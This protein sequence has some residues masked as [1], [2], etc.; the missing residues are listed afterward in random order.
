MAVAA[1]LGAIS[2]DAAHAQTCAPVPSGIVAWWPA[3]GTAND[4][5]GTN[6]G[7]L[8]GGAGFTT[9]IVGQAFS[10]DGVDGD[11]SF[12]N[13]PVSDLIA[14]QFTIEYWANPGSTPD[15]P[16]W[17]F[18]GSGHLN[19]DNP[20]TSYDSGLTFGDG[21]GNV[22]VMPALPN[23]M[24]NTWTHY[25]IVDDGTRYRVYV[26]GAESYNALIAVNPA[27]AGNR[28]FVIG[29]SGFD[30]G[31][32]EYFNG[33]LDEFTIYNRA[34]SASEIAG[35]YA[36]GPTGK[37]NVCGNGIVQ[38]GEQCDDGNMINGDGCDNNCTF[39][40]CG[41]MIVTAGEECD[42]GNLVSGDCCSST[43]QA[44]PSGQTCFDDGN[45]CTIDQCDGAG[46]CQHSL[47]P[48]NTPC[49]SD[50]NVC[51]DD[52]CDGAG[53]C[54]HPNNTASCDDGLFCDGADTCAGGICH[55]AGNPCAPESECNHCNEA[56]DTCFDPATTS[57]TS[58]GNP[59]TADAC[60]G[61]GMCTHPA[62]NAG[63]VCRAAAGQCDLAETCT[64]LSAS[65]P[66]DGFQP[67]GT[68]C[69]DGNAC[70][71]T[72]TCQA[73]TCTGTDP[74]DCDD[75][76]PCTV[77]SCA[78]TGG[79]VNDDAPATGCLTAAKSLLLLKESLVDD[80]KDKLI[81]KWIRGD[82]VDQA[83]LGD[84]TAS[85]SYALCLYDGPSNALISAMALPAGSGWSTLGTKG[86]KFNGT[87]PEGL[88][89]TLLSGGAAGKT[90]AL[91]KGQGAALPDPGLPFSYPVT[92]Q[93]RKIGSPVCLESAFVST[94][95]KKNDMTEFKA[96][97]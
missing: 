30:S 78:P 46:T 90:K 60:D 95:Q 14:S 41:N 15:R 11:V 7:N 5:V 50:G 64:G 32:Q 74:L 34:L 91:A 45:S 97:H 80:T 39:T 12:V 82:A 26:N 59:C 16:T 38:L 66:A 6:N 27:S 44:E 79:C 85:A 70:T 65:C 89:S 56:A 49:D 24:A 77:D 36:A 18:L 53:T 9:G 92:V 31:F 75:G 88:T 43:C 47:S 81:W 94:D 17:G 71:Q 86:Y 35:I 21:T 28:T 67:D 2:I 20:I 96:K 83:T 25:A 87:S 33:A 22:Q 73:G 48:V 54:T 69:D 42:D 1:Y 55:H 8:Q 58:D 52:I 3:E 72:D 84:P 51:T 93:L 68:T 19:T 61:A 62:G 29:Q 37:C 23:A 10:F 13:R 76:N 57:C 4:I 40:G 63:V